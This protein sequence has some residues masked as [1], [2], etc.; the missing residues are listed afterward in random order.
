[1]FVAIKSHWKCKSCGHEEERE[2]PPS[3]SL[4]VPLHNGGCLLVVIALLAFPILSRFFSPKSILIGD[5]ILVGGLALLVVIAS[6]VES[7]QRKR[8]LKIEYARR[9]PRCG[10]THQWTFGSRGGII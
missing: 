9:C 7:R 6:L 5:A 3:S 8:W 1:M 10:T 2:A 4:W